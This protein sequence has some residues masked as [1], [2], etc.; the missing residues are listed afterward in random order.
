MCLP[1]LFIKEREQ[2]SLHKNFICCSKMELKGMRNVAQ[3]DEGSPR[4]SQICIFFVTCEMTRKIL[5]TLYSAIAQAKF[6]HDALN[7]APQVLNNKDI[8]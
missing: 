4:R 5:Y 8:V 2:I 6:P 7:Y 3:L 1:Y